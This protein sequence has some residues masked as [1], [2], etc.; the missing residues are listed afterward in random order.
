MGRKV[1]AVGL[2]TVLQVI[3]ATSNQAVTAVECRRV[4]SVHNS[5]RDVN[6]NTQLGGHVWQ[7]I[8]GFTARPHGA[9]HGDRQA[10]KHYLTFGMIS[11]K[12]GTD[13]QI[14]KAI[15]TPKYV[16]TSITL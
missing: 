12:H 15:I 4:P 6:T 8:Y 7:H 9:H 5:I 10:G 14:F 11:N 1:F 16:Q 2:L 3:L 13:L